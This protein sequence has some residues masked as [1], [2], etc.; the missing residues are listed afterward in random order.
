MSLASLTHDDSLSAASYSSLPTISANFAVGLR[1]K[2]KELATLNWHHGHIQGVPFALKGCRMAVA[3]AVLGRMGSSVA[4]AA[5]F[6]VENNLH[7]LKEERSRL[8]YRGSMLGYF[9]LL[10]SCA[11]RLQRRLVAGSGYGH[12]SGSGAVGFIRMLSSIQYHNVRCWYIHKISTCPKHKT[13][14]L[15]AHVPRTPHITPA[16]RRIATPTPIQYTTQ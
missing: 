6:D 16:Q 10:L 3:G 12:F 13:Q 5:V 15:I 7:L 9:R 11:W 14:Q 1:S 8:L 2:A 4:R